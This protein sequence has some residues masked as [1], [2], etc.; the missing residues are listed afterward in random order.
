[1]MNKTVKIILIIAA[2]MVPVGII[3]AFMGIYAGGKFGWSLKFSE[4]GTK[5]GTDAVLKEQALDDFEELRIDVSTADVTVIRGD[6]FSISYKTRE[7]EEPEISQDGVTLTVKQ[8]AMGFVMFDFGF[9]ER[10]NEYTITVPESAT[11]I[12]V[13]IKSSSGDLSIDRV[14]VTGRIISSTG[15]VDLNDTEGE[16]LEIETSAGDINVDKVKTGVCSFGSSTGDINMLRLFTEDMS[17]NTSTG[18]IDINNSE[19]GKI[20]IDSSTGEAT[21]NLN[22]K[23]DAYSYDISSNT[24][25]ITINGNEAEKKYINDNGGKMKMQIHTSTGDIYVSVGDVASK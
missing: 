16:M 6:K 2:I 10:L 20:Y 23:P 19:V 8:P 17:C 1:M 5:V 3:I 25:D 12:D 15:D 21:L 18:D 9:S 7:G 14:N 22:G 4:G 11:P 24:G 13:D